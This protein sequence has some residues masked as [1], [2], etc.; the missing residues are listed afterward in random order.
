MDTKV[1]SFSSLKLSDAGVYTCEV[2]I[3]STL[4]REAVTA[5]DSYRLY[6]QSELKLTMTRM[7]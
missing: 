1:L 4:F 5:I 3:I 2:N 7:T 6:I